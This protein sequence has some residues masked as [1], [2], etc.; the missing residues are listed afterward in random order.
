MLGINLF[1]PQSARKA[2]NEYGQSIFIF[3]A[4]FAAPLREKTMI[5]IENRYNDPQNHRL[6]SFFIIRCGKDAHG[7]L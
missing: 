6:R 2:R 7:E 3:F 5:I 1:E 4:A